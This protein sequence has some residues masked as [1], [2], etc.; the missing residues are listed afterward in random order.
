MMWR[1]ASVVVGVALV[2]SALGVVVLASTSSVQALQQ[3]G[4]PHYFVLRQVAFLV[5]ALCAGLVCTRIDYRWWNTFAIPLALVSVV[6]LALALVPGVG[7]R[8]GGSSRWIGLG[9]VNFQPSEL[10]KL[11]SVVLLGWYL[12]RSQRQ[13]HEL[14]R[15][16][17]L[18]L[19]LL[20][21]MAGLI[22]IAPDFGTTMLVAL[23]GLLILFAGGSRIGHLTIA[24]F[25]GGVAFLLAVM[26]SPLR[27]RRVFAFLDPHE[28]A[29]DE[30]YQLLSA[31][32][33][34]VIGGAGGVGLGQSIQKRFYLPEA[35]TDFI[36]AIVGEELGL[37]ASL[38]VLACF[39]ALF[40]AGMRIA[41]HAPDVF[42]KLLALGI[43]L[44]VTLQAALNMA[45]VTGLVPTK[46]LPLP[47][48]SYGG[49]SLV[50]TMVMAG[51]LVSVGLGAGEEDP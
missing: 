5:V 14:G 23:V 6:L 10:A 28:Y 49:S 46:G 36:F 1:S 42:G 43:T 26:H 22:F 16:L 9:P 29:Q 39:V 50:M 18:P 4:Q 41:L 19:A 8:A 51:I 11:S 12:S 31:M 37:A 20:G 30:A 27:M 7:V 45:V 44:M 38:L 48:I 2:L 24:G 17:L 40:V 32:Y 13:A 47:F 25:I 33:A 34:F 21:S 15:G 35:H 3:H